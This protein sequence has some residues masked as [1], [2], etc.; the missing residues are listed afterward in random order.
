M[1]TAL[2]LVALASLALRS[3]PPAR[4]DAPAAL[5]MDE[6]IERL[7]PAGCEVRLDFTDWTA[8]E[9]PMNDEFERRIVA[10]AALSD[11]QWSRLL[12]VT[13]AVASWPRWP[14]D[15]PFAIA[16]AVPRSLGVCQIRLTPLDAG[17]GRAVAGETFA[18]FSG[19]M[20]MMREAQ[21][22][23]QPLASLDRGRHR[24]TFDVEVER[25]EPFLV[26]ADPTEPTG[27]VGVIAR[28][29][30]TIE[31]DVVDDVAEALPPAE[32]PDLDA[33]VA[34]AIGAAITQWHFED[35]GR[36]VLAVA[37]D[38]DLADHPELVEVGLSLTVELVR[39]GVTLATA[40]L[41]ASRLDPMAAANSRSPT[42]LR[43]CGLALFPTVPVDPSME[44]TDGGWS[45]RVTGDDRHL[46]GLWD[47]RRR[48]AGSIEVPLAEAMAAERARVPDKDGRAWVSTPVF[49]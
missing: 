41:V 31:V 33:A 28:F 32:G 4:S 20:A 34:S 3:V 26:F 17:V 1:S 14:H 11:E 19:T 18:S 23:Y 40:P 45:L 5:S 35:G 25:G 49:R 44:R 29:R 24:L 36:Q 16:M 8:I 30:H 22:R 27:P 43:L 7:P 10:G 47:A 6:L 48:W 37:V 46:I 13:R 42:A 2:A 39:D 38:P 21:A 12:V 15:H 9:D